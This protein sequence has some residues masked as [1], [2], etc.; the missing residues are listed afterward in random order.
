M[1]KLHAH[2]D[3]KE[4]LVLLMPMV[5]EVQLLLVN[6]K[7]KKKVTQILRPTQ[8]NKKFIKSKIRKESS[9]TENPRILPRK[10]HVIPNGLLHAAKSILTVSMFEF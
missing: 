9:L 10:V 2:L 1:L 5:P 6:K 3:S 4:T 8:G 7:K